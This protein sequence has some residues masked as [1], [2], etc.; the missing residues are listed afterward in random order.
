MIVSVDPRAAKGVRLIAVRKKDG[1]LRSYLVPG[2]FTDRGNL[3][4]GPTCP[5]ADIKVRWR[6]RSVRL[7]M[8]SKCLHHG[9]YG[10]IRFAVLTEN[11]ADSD[12][13]P[14]TRSG[15]LGS[16]RWLPRG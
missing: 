15:D 6:A 2:A 5:G 4:S 1:T 13:A 9:N 12:Y 14:E 16:S 7:V 11:G 3:G 8:P 10:A